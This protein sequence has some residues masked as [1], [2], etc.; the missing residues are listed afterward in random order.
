MFCRNGMV[1]SIALAEKIQ[2]QLN[3]ASLPGKIKIGL[4]ACPRNCCSALLKDIG[5]YSNKNGLIMAVGGNGGTKPRIGD[6]VQK[7]LSENDALSLID[8][9]IAL[10]AAQAHRKER[11]ARF[12][13]R[14]GLAQ[15]KKELSRE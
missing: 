8:K 3:D 14:I 2:D 12:I 7:G 4:S 10:Y 15:I 1:N 5:I 13:E 11:T 9:F 6:V